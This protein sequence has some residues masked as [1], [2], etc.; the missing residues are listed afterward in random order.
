MLSNSRDPS[1]GMSMVGCCDIVELE[2]CE[3]YGDEVRLRR[4]IWRLE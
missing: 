4:G 1:V 2:M 3:V